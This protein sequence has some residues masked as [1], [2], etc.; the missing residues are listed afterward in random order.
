MFSYRN[1]IRQRHKG[2]PTYVVYAEYIDKVRNDAE[3]CFI[4]VKA[5]SSNEFNNLVDKM[6]R[7]AKTI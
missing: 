6:A 1:N 5:H 3:V 7:V 4:K 2:C